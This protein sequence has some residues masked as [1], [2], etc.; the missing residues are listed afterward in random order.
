[1]VEAGGK[2]FVGTR[3]RRIRLLLFTGA[4]LR[5]LVA[6]RGHH[7]PLVGL[8][9][10]LNFAVAR[11]DWGVEVSRAEFGRRDDCDLTGKERKIEVQVCID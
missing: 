9:I 3:H 6:R 7:R 1:M 11:G 2:T 8:L 4:Y 5:F 10:P